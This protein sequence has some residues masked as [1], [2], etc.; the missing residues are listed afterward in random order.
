LFIE[1]DRERKGEDK[2]GSKK[3]VKEMDI[4]FDE[5]DA[6]LFKLLDLCQ[7]ILG[8]Q[9]KGRSLSAMTSP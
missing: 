6:E 4:G 9:F 7:A 8:F 2:R 5:R 1:V 3:K